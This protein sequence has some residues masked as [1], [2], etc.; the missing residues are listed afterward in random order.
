M[1]QQQDADGASL[2]EEKACPVINIQL[3]VGLEML[4]DLS[5][6][7]NRST[8]PRCCHRIWWI[9]RSALGKPPSG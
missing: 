5:T 6:I 7:S 9:N 1:C 4:V 8:F 2:W 3:E